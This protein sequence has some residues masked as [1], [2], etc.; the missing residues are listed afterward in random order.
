G[1]DRVSTPPRNREGAVNLLA[2]GS[3]IPRKGYDVL[4][5]ALARLRHLPWRLV[6]AGD[7][8]RSPQTSRRLRADIMRLRLADRITLLGAVAAEEGA[9]LYLAAH[10]FVLPSRSLAY[11]MTC[12]ETNAP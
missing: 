9:P 10:L 12:T 6:I 3:V 7:C 11:R 8:G 4:V 2:V 5:A 1:T